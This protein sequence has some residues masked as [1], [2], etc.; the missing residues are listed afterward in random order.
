MERF[1]GP[2]AADELA[3]EPI[4][5]LWVRWR[6]SVGPEVTRRGDDPGAEVVVPD[7]VGHHARGQWVVWVGDPAR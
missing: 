2:L 1:D 6:A 5:E 4:Q 7:S 3:R